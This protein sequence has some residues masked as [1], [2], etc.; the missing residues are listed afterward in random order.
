[1]VEMINKE[2]KNLIEN[3][4]LALSTV[5]KSSKPH[6]IAVGYSK[7]I[8][9]KII[10]S[11]IFMRGTI[12]NLKN[13]ENISLAVWNKTWE[14]RCVGYELKGKAKYFTSGKWKKFVEEMPQNK[15]YH[16]KGAII[17]SVKKIKRLA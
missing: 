5:D 9:S 4:A 16:V 12:K 8:D 7:V 1:M 17:V 11:N 13:N 15:K 10:I 2:L 3:S 14:K 6:T